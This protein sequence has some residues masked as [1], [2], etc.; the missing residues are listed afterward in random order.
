M[1]APAPLTRSTPVGEALELGYQSLITI[2]LDPDIA[3]W[4]KTVTAAGRDIGE[5]INISNQHTVRYHQKTAKALIDIGDIK[6]NCAFDP[7]VGPQI[8]A[9]LGVNT[10][11]TTTYPN[12]D[13]EAM[14]GFV[15]SFT[16]SGMSEAGQ[17]EA[18]VTIVVTNR[19]PAT[20]AEQGPV[21]TA[22][23]GT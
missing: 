15:K 22:Y 3:F 9:I 16:P 14:F 6:I 17:P 23:A 8:D 5:A 20:G 7:A 13:T 19:D 12:G 1:T 10:T 18:E 11:I 21:Y 4:E 2:A